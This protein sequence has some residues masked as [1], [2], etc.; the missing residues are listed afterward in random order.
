MRRLIASLAATIVAASFVW[1][2]VP[3]SAAQEPTRSE[4][5]AARAQTALGRFEATKGA[6]ETSHALAYAAQAYAWLSPQGWEDPT[7]LAYLD[8]VRARRNPDGGYGLGYAY[9]WS[10]D[11]TVNPAGTT[12]TVTVADH[13]GPVLL[14]AYK[15]G[16]ASRAEVQTLVSLL[17]STPRI[18][19]NSSVYGQCIAYSRSPNDNLPWACVHNVSAGAARFLLDAAAAGIGAT[20]L[21]KLVTDVTRREV[22]A[23]QPTI[24]GRQ[25]WWRYA[26]TRQLNDADHN[27]YSAESMYHLS[28]AVG[29]EAAYQHMVT[30]WA[31]NDGA[32]LAHM[33]LTALPGGPASPDP[34]VPGTTWCELGDR[35]VDEFDQFVASA[36]TARRA[37]QA[38]YFAARNARAC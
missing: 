6:S 38:A 28:Y 20:G 35:W 16:A 12:Y 23:Y 34:S 11:G 18:Q 15:A 13:V 1:V 19:S 14:D 10:N 3:V 25:A 32:P 17:M 27:S 9:D 7:A 31:D 4:Q 30:E 8:Q 5:W 2:A 22:Y 24:E 37:A 21:H 36:T 33:R 29:R 26:D